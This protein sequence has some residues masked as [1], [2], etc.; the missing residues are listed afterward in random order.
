MDR[1]ACRTPGNLRGCAVR[2]ARQWRTPRSQR[3]INPISD[4]AHPLRA[5]IQVQN[6][7]FCALHTG[8]ALTLERFIDFAFTVGIADPL[9]DE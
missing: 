8:T 7:F 9:V 1:A 6:D 5:L 2:R 3:S 4:A